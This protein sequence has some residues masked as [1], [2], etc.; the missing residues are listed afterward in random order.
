MGA[1]PRHDRPAGQV[2]L[3][4]VEEHDHPLILAWQNDPEDWWVDDDW[5]MDD[6]RT[7]TLEDVRESEA[8]AKVERPPVPRSSCTAGRPV[9]RIGLDRFRE[10][11]QVCSLYVFIGEH[12]AWGRRS[13]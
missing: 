4:P 9:G 1:C 2:L 3:R 7:F 6:E 10:R 12:G 8:R 5:W 13:R 11:D